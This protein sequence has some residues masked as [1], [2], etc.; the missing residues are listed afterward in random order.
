VNTGRWV[1][2]IGEGVAALGQQLPPEAPEKLAQLLIELKRWNA[3][4]N[5]TSVRDD[6]AV[7]PAHILDSLAVRPWIEGK[8]VL[9]FGTG[10]GFP[11]LPLA[12]AA[13]DVRFE[14]LDSSGKKIAFVQHMI[15]VL[16]IENAVAVKARVEHYA[17]ATRFDTVVTR[18][19][20]A[21][22]EILKLSG[23][24]VGE[25]SVLLALK[26]KYPHDE[27]RQL[28]DMNELSAVWDY[29]VTE[30]DVPGLE[31]HA[32]HIIALRKRRVARE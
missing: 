22:P 23:H 10:A 20:A 5:L 16:N 27:L 24:L 6:A 11:G 14:L 13:P 8:R 29:N 17:P 1:A 3:R 30:L 26:G 4:I 32:R 31:S 25:D 12:I 2:S 9:D 7:V 15:G 28:N 21:I 18:A 19:F